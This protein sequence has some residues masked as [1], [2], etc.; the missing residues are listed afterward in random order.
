MVNTFLRHTGNYLS[1]GQED[2]EHEFLINNIYI[3]DLLEC[4]AVVW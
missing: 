2:E 4:E 3:F 1:L